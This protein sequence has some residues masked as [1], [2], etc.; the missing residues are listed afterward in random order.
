MIF[1][2]CFNQILTIIK[3]LEDRILKYRDGDSNDVK[4]ADD[5]ANLKGRF[6]NAQVLLQLAALSDL[7][8]QFGK[9]VNVSQKVNILPYERIENVD[10]VSIKCFIQFM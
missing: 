6:Y 10:I 3:C 8:E 2:R 4:K 7:Y 9:L 5:A 1:F